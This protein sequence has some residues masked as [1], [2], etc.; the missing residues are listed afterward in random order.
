MKKKLSIHVQQTFKIVNV[1]VA[2][3][4]IPAVASEWDAGGGSNLNWDEVTNWVGDVDPSNPAATD[5]LFKETGWT[6]TSTP[7]TNIINSTRTILSL[8]YQYDSATNFHTTEIA[9]GV[10]LNVGGTAL[11]HVFLV[12]GLTGEDLH[13][14]TVFQ[15]EGTLNISQVGGVFSVGNHRLGNAP[16]SPSTAEL[17]MRGL[18]TFQATLGATGQ[19][20]VGAS[21][22]DNTL[23]GNQITASDVYL[24][25]NN[26]ITAGILRVGSTVPNQQV[27][28]GY[29]ASN[30]YLGETNVLNVDAIHVGRG[31][32]SKATGNLAF[33][34]GVIANSPTVVIRGADGVSAVSEMK[35][36]VNDGGG[37]SNGQAGSIDFS[38]GSVDALIEDLIIGSG[39]GSG[40]SAN[41]YASGTLTMDAGTIEV[42]NVLVGENRGGANT[43]VTNQGVLNVLG[44]EF[45]AD[46]FVLAQHTGSVQK[47]AGTLNVGGDGIVT[48]NNGIV[49]GTR[50]GGTATDV[51]T[52]TINLTG[53]TLVAHGDI[54][55]GS[56]TDAISSTVNLQG[57]ALDL[58]GNA[59]HVKNFNV[60]SGALQNVGE[61]NGGEDLVK[62]TGGTL[63]LNGNNTYTGGTIVEAG[64]VHLAGTLSNANVVVENGAEFELLAAGHLH[65][66]IS[67]VGTADQFVT[68]A[69]GGSVFDGTLQFN[70]DADFGDT[71]WTLFSGTSAG[72]FT[73]L[74]GIDLAGAFATSLSSVG[75]NIWGASIGE[76]IFEFN[77]ESG[78]FSITTIPEPGSMA[79]LAVTFGSFFIWRRRH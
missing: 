11:S 79:L 50:T 69:G 21:L 26:T 56:G 4:A 38:G 52:A 45:I 3:M 63:L 42:T 48:A 32:T 31:S 6:S 30:L 43:A 59:I 68:Q 73:D 36:G 1:W 37:T 47:V 55:E 64:T 65:F 62:T 22:Q 20:N 10:T 12:G 67:G 8:S 49:M 60:E 54:A 14:K 2:A 16:N 17:D 57:G 72:D 51:I 34:S 58:D 66:N 44:G 74:A 53:G 29:I 19:F 77:T 7:P 23:G 28:V 75:G 24:A 78:T 35:I 41:A 46:N 13:T 39:R 70:L 61:I 40:T 33:D 76:R 18:G 15:G 27:S 25:N 71:S 5:V 9:D